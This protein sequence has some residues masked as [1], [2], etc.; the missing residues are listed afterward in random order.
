M[1]SRIRSLTEKFFELQQF[2]YERDV[3]LKT[4]S[5]QDITLSYV[6]EGFTDKEKEL[7]GTIGVLL[8]NKNVMCDLSAILKAEE[9]GT[10]IPHLLRMMVI[11][12]QFSTTARQLADH[13]GIVTFTQS[14]LESIKNMY[15]PTKTAFNA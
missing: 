8:E 14:E 12:N 1:F 10:K 9:I 15:L 13:L 7:G 2:N 11:A 4:K 5:D 3:S 6:I